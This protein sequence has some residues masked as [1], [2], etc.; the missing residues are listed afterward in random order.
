M[1]VNTEPAIPY[2]PV[3]RGLGGCGGT[4]V[5]RVLSALPRVLLLSETN[6]RSAHLYGG[7]L[8]PIE[9][10]R[11][12]HPAMAPIVADFDP[13][14]I[15]YPPRFGALLQHIHLAAERDNRVLVVRDF[16]YADFIGVP[17]I[18]P[19][20][21]DLS[22][23]LA[24][25][26]CF[27]P[28]QAVIVR[29]PADQLAS[30]RSH[31]AIRP[32]LRAE[33]FIEAYHAFLSATVRAPRFRYEDFVTDPANKFSDL[34]ASLGIPWDPVALD[35]FSQVQSVTGN[36]QKRNETEIKVSARSAA[37]LDADR[38]LNESP[39]YNILIETLG[40]L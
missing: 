12:W 17:F 20:P 35:H 25:A 22:L 19:V 23:D 10:I 4:L 14:E 8:N 1:I 9:Q 38:E 21:N 40:Y 7:M 13:G 31:A 24:I 33:R 32:V 3:L 5:S 16:N 39:G 11:K 6:P 37:A 36:M 18:W 27:T 34:A 30:L 2:L 26:G 29:H 28:R 15:G